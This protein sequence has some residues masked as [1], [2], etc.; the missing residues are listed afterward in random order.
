MKDAADMLDSI[1]TPTIPEDNTIPSSINME[2]DAEDDAEILATTKD[3]CYWWKYPPGGE[4]EPPRVTRHIISC[5][6]RDYF[7]VVS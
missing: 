4:V 1:N 3:Y 7:K 6:F 2:F 5:H